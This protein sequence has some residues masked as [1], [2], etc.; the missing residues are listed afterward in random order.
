MRGGD[1]YAWSEIRMAHSR[2]IPEDGI[3]KGHRW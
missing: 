2:K 3:T 1:M